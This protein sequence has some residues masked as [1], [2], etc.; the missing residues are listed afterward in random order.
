MMRSNRQELIHIFTK[1]SREAKLK[2]LLGKYPVKKKSTKPN[3]EIKN[4]K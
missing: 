3:R 4:N 2:E 1:P